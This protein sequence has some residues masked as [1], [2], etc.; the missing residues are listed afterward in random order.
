MWLVI[1]VGGT[2]D[3]EENITKM[4]S[5][6]II[7]LSLILRVEIKKKERGDLVKM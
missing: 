4:L 2:K 1:F 5:G 3:L 7:D 6:L